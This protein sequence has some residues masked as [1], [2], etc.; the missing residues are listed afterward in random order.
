MVRLQRIRA[1]DSALEI[2][3]RPGKIN[4]EMMAMSSGIF[5]WLASNNPAAVPLPLLRYAVPALF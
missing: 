2:V 5:Q 4:G 3:L 1:E